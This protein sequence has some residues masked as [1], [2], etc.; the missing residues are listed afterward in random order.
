M[1]TPARH[2]ERGHVPVVDGATADWLLRELERFRV[3][4]ALAGRPTANGITPSRLIP[5]FR[6]RHELAAGHDLGSEIRAALAASQFL[7][8]LCSP[9][10]AQ[11]HWTNAEI[12]AFKR[13]RPD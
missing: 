1:T 3:P 9:A 5:V 2:P 13:S 10:A 11:S 4:A 8:V 7:V 12:D 6:D